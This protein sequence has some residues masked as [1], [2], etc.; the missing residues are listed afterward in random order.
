MEKATTTAITSKSTDNKLRQFSFGFQDGTQDTCTKASG[1]S[2]F[3]EGV[4]TFRNADLELESL[5]VAFVR[6]II[7]ERA[8]LKK[9]I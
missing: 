7:E 1:F 5:R 3:L 6:D 4:R 2:S 8:E 9:K